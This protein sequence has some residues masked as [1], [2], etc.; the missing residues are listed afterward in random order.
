[1]TWVVARHAGKMMTMTAKGMIM[2][3]LMMGKRETLKMVA[4]VRLLLMHTRR[5]RERSCQLH[6]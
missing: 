6:K 2:M 3:V 1:M 5:V 4:A